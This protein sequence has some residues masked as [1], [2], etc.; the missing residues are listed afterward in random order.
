M[1]DELENNQCDDCICRQRSHIKILTMD[2]GVGSGSK[3]LVAHDEELSSC[4]QHL[5]KKLNK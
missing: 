1:Y 4:L 5:Q 3:V 2:R